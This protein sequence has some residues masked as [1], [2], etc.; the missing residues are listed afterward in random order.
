VTGELL[1][2]DAYKKHAAEVLPTAEDEKLLNEITQAK[3][4]V[5]QM[6]MS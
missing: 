4:W 2:A 5:I 3:D 6:Q 1:S